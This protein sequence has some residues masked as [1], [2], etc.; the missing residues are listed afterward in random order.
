M[1]K[2]FVIVALF[3]I[4]ICAYLFFA[5]GV[6]RFIKLPTL[7]EKVQ[8]LPQNWKTIDGNSVQLKDKITI[9]GFGGENI[10]EIKGSATNLAHKI[11]SKNRTFTDFQVVYIIPDGMQNQ[12]EKQLVLPLQ[13]DVDFSSWSFV[14][15]PKS[16]IATF[17]D[18]FKLQHKLSNQIST[19]LVFIIDKDLKLRGRKGKNKKGEEEYREGYDTQSAADLHNE[20]ADDVKVILAE[21]RLARKEN[22][23]RKIN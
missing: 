6:N 19:P 13:R 7:T 4:P 22:N 3:I 9:I 11:Y 10:D 15:A 2:L 14:Y 16:E 21:Y 20:M 12:I 23:N 18:S 8:E 1:K 5:S 17:Y